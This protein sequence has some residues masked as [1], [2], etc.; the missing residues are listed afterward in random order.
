MF[1]LFLNPWTMMAGGA[2]ISSPILIHL[3][4]RLR[5][6]RVRWAAMEFLLKSQKR[7]RRRLII[8]QLLLLLLRILLVLLIAFLLARFVGWVFA[9]SNQ[10]QNTTHVVVLDDTLS[11]TDHWR[12]E[13]GDRQ[14]FDKARTQVVQLAKEINQAPGSQRFVVLR[15][16]DAPDRPFFQTDRLNKEAVDR[17]EQELNG[18]KCTL[19]HVK[20]AGSVAAA[21]DLLSKYPTDQRLLHIF[22]DFR[23]QDWSG[24]EAQGVSKVLDEVAATK[25]KIDLVDC[26]H[27]TRAPTQKG[28]D[29]HSNLAVVDLR[30]ET[31][32]AAE[33]TAVIFTVTV[34]NYSST[35]RDN[36]QVTVKV[37]GKVHEES[38]TPI[39]TLRPG[40]TTETFV[41]AA[42]QRPQGVKAS[43]PY[44]A[45]VSAS[46]EKADEAEG[47]QADNSRYTMI[48]IRKEVPV[49]VVDSDLRDPPRSGGDTDQI[50]KVFS[51]ARG[52]RV[53]RRGAD[54]LKNAN[55]N[56]YPTIFL[57]NVPTLKPEEKKNLEEFV[58]QGGGLVVCMGD[59]VNPKYYNDQLYADGKGLFP[60]PLAD[61]ASKPLSEDDQ[62]KRLF[63]AQYKLFFRDPTHPVVRELVPQRDLFKFLL[64]NRYF[65][66]QR[67]KWN[68]EP[69]KVVEVMTLPNERPVTDYAQ[70][71]KSIRDRLDQLAREPQYQKYAPGLARYQKEVGASLAPDEPLYRLGNALDEMVHDVGDPAKPERPNLKEFWDLP[72][73][74]ELRNQVDR[75]REAVQF[76]DPLAVVRRFGKGR[77][78]A[79]LTTAGQDWN[80]WAGFFPVSLSYPI[81][82][83]EMQRY[84]TSVEEGQEDLTVGSTINV[85][86]D[87]EHHE[88]EVHCFRKPKRDVA[89]PAQPNPK[90][91]SKE[92]EEALDPQT[93]L[94]DLAKQ[95]G[96]GAFTRTDQPGVYLFKLTHVGSANRAA[97]DEWY[98]Y[99]VN[100]DTANES[101]LD[102]SS[103]EELER[104]AAAS[105]GQLTVR[106]ADA[107]L[108]DEVV[109]RH[110]D[111]AESPWPFLVFLIVLVLEQA[112]AMHLSFH[113]KGGEAQLPAQAVRPR[114]TA[115]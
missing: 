92:E 49:L 58:R 89:G 38:M 97:R 99:P 61:A 7:N 10:G 83:L 53:V 23:R 74:K 54:E 1:E 13:D 66:V 60:V 65:P 25:T 114:A 72:D 57:L 115:A 107:P 71:A 98:A 80:N 90:R 109:N 108:T 14:C 29:A 106:A 68:P 21:R 104:L 59:R 34:A 105:P 33:G 70:G 5:Y 16:S 9:L 15:L 93:G 86:L 12:D 17:L 79:L 32:V 18:I 37:D 55:L 113:L 46:L 76:G 56:Q 78:V 6:R 96:S 44:F 30:P 2:L 82:V 4:N 94:V 35:N 77:V 36:V 63:D 73:L 103:S 39:P 11:M 64:I 47:I 62:V 40:L 91:D 52:Y 43:Q 50:Q 111:L 28:V 22:S 110:P 27:P 67:A 8:E 24:P 45:Q 3:I 100:V 19:R 95:Q 20:P 101:R 41:V 42:F 88:P 48:E 85:P 69:G 81:L 102:R 26:A 31:R 84:L 112:L 87:R 51:A 75:L